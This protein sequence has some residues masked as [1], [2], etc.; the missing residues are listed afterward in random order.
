LSTIAALGGPLCDGRQDV[1]FNRRHAAFQSL[2]GIGT[3]SK[4]VTCKMLISPEAAGKAFI[5]LLGCEPY[6]ICYHSKHFT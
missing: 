1:R 6:V 2:L 5:N 4:P 3:R